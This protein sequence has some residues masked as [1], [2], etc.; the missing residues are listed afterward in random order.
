MKKVKLGKDELLKQFHDT[1]VKLDKF[2]KLYDED[3]V[4]M[5]KEISVKLRIM[6]HNTNRSKS[7]IWQLK[8]EHIK[9]LDRAVKYDPRSITPTH[10]LLEIRFTKDWVKLL[11]HLDLHDAKLVTFENW[12]NSKKVI[13]DRKK[14]IFTRKKVVLEVAN[15]DG[16]AH[17]DSSVN[18][19]YFD[20]SRANSLG[21]IYMNP[22]TQ[23]DE[24]LNDPIPGSIR[25]IAFEALETFKLYDIEKESKLR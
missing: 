4:S 20:I 6:F 24:P 13:V 21:W 11:P 1:V 23:R 19:H 17:V 8:L 25:Q 3:D 7:L 22:K 2:C 15:T 16:G 10:G 12:W 18:Q 9:F 14:N 5:A